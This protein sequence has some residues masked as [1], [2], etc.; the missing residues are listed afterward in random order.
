MK[1][2]LK[3][4]A[5]RV[6]LAAKEAEFAG[7]SFSPDGRTLF[8]SILERATSRSEVVCLSGYALNALVM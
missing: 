6:A 7:L 1:G 5:F 2:P 8:L 3:G 4:G